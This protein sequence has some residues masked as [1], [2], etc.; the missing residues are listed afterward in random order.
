VCACVCLDFSCSVCVCP[1]LEYRR[2]TKNKGNS[3][4]FLVLPL[5]F[6]CY[7]DLWFFLVSVSYPCISRFMLCHILPTMFAPGQCHIGMFLASVLL[8]PHDQKC[9]LFTHS[10][11]MVFKGNALMCCRICALFSYLFH[12]NWYTFSAND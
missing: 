9:E 8:S 12:I 1:N 2:L 3:A 6:A 11:K 4:D 7:P 10:A 5:I